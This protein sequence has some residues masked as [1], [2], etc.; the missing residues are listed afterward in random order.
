M[1]TISRKTLTIVIAI[2]VISLGATIAAAKFCSSGAVPKG[3][4]AFAQPGWRLAQPITY[5]NLTIFPVVTA[6][7]PNTSEFATLD[8]ALASGDVLVTEQRAS[9]RR[10]RD[11]S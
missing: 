1:R 3:D 6:D 11:G 8:E 9:M 4:Q 7:D 2:I 10:M 5:D